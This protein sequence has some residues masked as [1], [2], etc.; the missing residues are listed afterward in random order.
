M[1]ERYRIVIPVDIPEIQ[2]AF[3]AGIQIATAANRSADKFISQCSMSVWRDQPSTNRS[4]GVR[5]TLSNSL[6]NRIENS[7]IDESPEPTWPNGSCA[8]VHSAMKS[9]RY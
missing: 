2:F 3:I 4:F 7:R 6:I 5:K 8:D 1:R 9:M